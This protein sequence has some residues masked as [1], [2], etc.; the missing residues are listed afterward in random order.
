MH[1]KK[2]EEFIELIR[3]GKCRLL[4]I[5]G[6][7]GS[8]KNTMI[9]LFGE[10]FNWD[11]VRYKDQKSKY[12]EDTFGE[13]RTLE[14]DENKFYPDDLDNMLSFVNGLR[15]STT[16]S[17]D[18]QAVVRSSFCKAARKPAPLQQK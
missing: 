7:S 2:K 6:Q 4:F 14:Y 10:A 15:A 8:A 13:R 11:V 17:I 1:K 9:D 18:K 3:G 16:T 12:V 5:Q